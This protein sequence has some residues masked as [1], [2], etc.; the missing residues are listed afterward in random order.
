MALIRLPEDTPVLTQR[1]AALRWQQGE[2]VLSPTACGA[3]AETR[4]SGQTYPG[5]HVHCSSLPGPVVD[6]LAG[7]GHLHYPVLLREDGIWI[8]PD[9]AIFTQFVPIDDT[10]SRGLDPAWARALRDGRLDWQLRCPVLPH[11]DTLAG[12]LLR[13]AQVASRLLPGWEVRTATTTP[14]LGALGEALANANGDLLTAFLDRQHTLLDLACQYHAWEL[15]EHLWMRGVRWGPQSRNDAAPAR[16]L[17]EVWAKPATVGGWPETRQA[18]AKRDAW[19]DR[20]LTRM[21]ALPLKQAQWRPKKVLPVE[22]G[23]SGSTLEP[24]FTAWLRKTL[25]L[26]AKDPGMLTAADTP[27]LARWL[28][29]WSAAGMEVADLLAQP[30]QYGLRAQFIQEWGDAFPQIE[31][32]LHRLQ[33]LQHQGQLTQQLPHGAA[34]QRTRL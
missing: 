10:P 17:L 7:L 21:G 18:R 11:H 3:L 12:H 24:L 27:A 23:R 2:L 14:G 34:S 31:G 13:H 28:A 4:I 20:W 32:F 16:A 8:D 1:P 25:R 15:A 22:L 6:R 9:W 30:Q 5:L 19:L 29:A 26:G 33:S